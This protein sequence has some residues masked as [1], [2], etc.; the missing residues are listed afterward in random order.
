MAKLVLSLDGIVEGHYFLDKPRFTIGRNPEN[1]VCINNP[2]ISNIH[3]VI[4]TM[5]NDHVLEDA[6]STNGVLVNREAVTKHI[7]QNNDTIGLSGYALRYINQRATPDM[8]FDK[9]MISHTTLLDTHGTHPP[10]VI[11]PALITATP[12]ARLVKTNFPLG[13]VINLHEQ[14]AH[15]ARKEILIS[16]PLRTF[17]TPGKQMLMIS[18]R[19][20]GYFITH[21]AGKKFPHVNGKRMGTQPQLLHEHDVIEAVDLKLKFFLHRE[22]ETQQ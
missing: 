11:Q 12:A 6:G 8:D 17:G 14:G 1:D 22:A 21:V 9:T 5:S 15:L 16:A 7:L 18:R 20:H 19:P 10:H 3:A 4:L 2:A 13:G